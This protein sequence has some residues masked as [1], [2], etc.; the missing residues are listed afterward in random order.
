MLFTPHQIKKKVVR[1]VGGGAGVKDRRD[2]YR[3]L[4]G[5]L[6]ET[7]RSFRRPRRRWEDNIKKYIFKKW[8]LNAWT[9]LVSFRIGTGNWRL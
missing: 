4:V 8:D 6:E 3:V 1:G 2:A 5:R 9:G 7:K